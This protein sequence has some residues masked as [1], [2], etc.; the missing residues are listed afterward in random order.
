MSEIK[1]NL[2][3]SQ[4]ILCGTIH[5]SVAD[6][7]IAAL[8][9]EPE[10]IDELELALTRYERGDPPAPHFA[11]FH[12]LDCI[13]EQPWDAGLMIID[14]PARLVATMSNY[15]YPHRECEVI[16]HDGEASGVVT[17]P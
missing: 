11:F 4:R 5:G 3:D 8:G 9:A 16:C 6:R 12:E 15:S 2:I 14:L 17:I 13:D 7:A 1:L 10:T